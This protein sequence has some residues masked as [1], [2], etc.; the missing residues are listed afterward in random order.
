MASAKVDEIWSK[1]VTT[2]NSLVVLGVLDG[3]NKH[4]A[5]I[6]KDTLLTVPADRRGRRYKLFLHD[7]LRDSTP[8]AVLVCAIGLGKNRAADELS[9]EDCNL[10][11]PLIKTSDVLNH[12]TLRSLAIECQIPRS[13]HGNLFTTILYHI[14]LPPM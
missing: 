3:N 9:I 1:L 12:P 8:G 10:L 13:V 2:A 11:L 5:K 6:A 7:V 14:C 4:L